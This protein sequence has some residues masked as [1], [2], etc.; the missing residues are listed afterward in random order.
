MS[1]ANSE[2]TLDYTRIVG[3]GVDE[4]DRRKEHN[5]NEQVSAEKLRTSID[6]VKNRIFYGLK[7]LSTAA[8]ERVQK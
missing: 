2:R 7:M 5:S 8:L 3:R 4:L 6:R 1:T